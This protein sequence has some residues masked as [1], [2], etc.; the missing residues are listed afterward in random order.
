MNDLMGR[1][2]EQR[3]LL[4]R[5]GRVN[6]GFADDQADLETGPLTPGHTRGGPGAT[7]QGFGE[8]AQ[9]EEFYGL[10]SQVKLNTVKLK[11]S[12]KKVKHLGEQFIESLQDPDLKEQKEKAMNQEK[13]AAAALM[14]STGALMQKIKAIEEAKAGSVDVNDPRGMDSGYRM[15]ATASISSRQN[16]KEA[17]TT[18]IDTEKK[19]TGE[20]RERLRRHIHIADGSEPS[21]ER[22]DELEDEAPDVFAQAMMG[23][24]D[25]QLA[26]AVHDYA[27]AKEEQVSQILSNQNEIFELWAQLGIILDQQHEML[28]NIYDNLEKSKEY[29]KEA[30]D[31]LKVVPGYVGATKRMYCYIIV[32]LII[33][34]CIVAVPVYISMNSSSSDSS[35]RRAVGLALGF[36]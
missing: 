14:Q 28:T 17:M 35:G 12:T 36:I 5:G 25:R 8:E 30:N 29:V 11:Q 1:L 23:K 4:E 22:L 34:L 31:Q 27:R 10:I 20:L 19:M 9:L 16:W 24:A 32:G 15:I 13:E 7:E 6:R 3:R 21:E 2:T 18:Y 33:I 26:L